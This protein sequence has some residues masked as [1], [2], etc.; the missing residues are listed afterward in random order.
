MHLLPTTLVALLLAGTAAAQP[1]SESER[2]EERAPTGD[3]ELS[4]AALEGLMAQPSDRALPIL[5]RVLAG[6]QTTL[7]KQR[8]LFVLSQIDAPEARE[9]LAQASRSP[10][11]ALRREA[12]R[13]IGIGGD[14]K[15]LDSLQAI[16]NAGDGDVKQEVLQA[17]LIAGRKE[18]VYQAALNAKTED[19]AT[20]A[21]HML[22]VMGA[23]DELR[24][25]GDRPKASRGLVD[26]FAI[27]GDLASLRK[28]VEGGSEQSIRVDAVRKIG[29][30]QSDAAR[31]ALRE[32]YSSSKDEEIRDAARQGMLIA[33][34]EQGV[35]A[36]YRAA[37]TSEEKRELLRTLTMMDGDVALQ[38]IDAALEKK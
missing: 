4:L 2:A 25:L 9:L 16:Y 28:I 35:L 21:I 19:E 32:I 29:I 5:K 33:H 23:A 14:P 13:S 18:A 12:I 38:A 22:G 30:V 11:S 1:P 34:D 24:K 37:K 20:D 27:S 15:S 8:A 10:D 6:P 3:E 36:L 7:V 26:A 17:W 31:A